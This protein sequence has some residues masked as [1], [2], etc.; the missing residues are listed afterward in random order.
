MELNPRYP[1]KKIRHSKLPA[2]MTAKWSHSILE[3][4]FTPMPKR[5]LRAIGKIFK[6]EHG[7]VDLAVVLSVADYK[8]LNLYRLPSI[9]YLAWNAGLSVELFRQ[10]LEQLVIKELVIR[11][12]SD[13]DLDISL[14]P[15]EE[16]VERLTP[17]DA[18]TVREQGDDKID[19]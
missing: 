10:R 15:L 16:T 2:V 14:A 1:R 7:A 6:G 17:D 9:E 13:Q 4:G 18:D 3:E 5:L 8:R 12:G 11:R 19:L